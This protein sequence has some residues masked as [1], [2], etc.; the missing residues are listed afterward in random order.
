MNAKGKARSPL[1]TGKNKNTLQE[2][3]PF[4][5]FRCGICCTKYH[6]H[7]SDIEAHRIT[8]ELGITWEEWLD[9]YTEKRWPRCDSYLLYRN[10]DGACIFLDQVPGGKISR[11]RIHPFRP[12]SCC[13]WSPGLYRPECQEGLTRFW[14]L[15]VNEKGTIA[16]TREKLAD[17]S[18][19]LKLL[20]SPDH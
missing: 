6:V 19:F 15:T 4:P 2:E 1:P 9:K 12:S 5:C 14:E 16:G 20:S 3:T 10:E 8:D 11:C 7:V 18:A 13:E 17:F